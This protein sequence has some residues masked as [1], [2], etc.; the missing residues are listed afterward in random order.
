MRINKYLIAIWLICETISPNAANAH[1]A[2]AQ[3]ISQIIQTN[4]S[5]KEFTC[6]K[7]RICGVL[8]IP[9]FYQNRGWAPAWI[10]SDGSLTGNVRELINALQSSPLEGLSPEIYHLQ[11]VQNLVSDMHL[12]RPGLDPDRFFH[13]AELDILLTDSFLLYASHLRSGRVNPETI[14]TEWVAFHTEIDLSAIL[15]SALINGRI[16]ETLFQLN[17]PHPGYRR[18]KDALHN[19]RRI[20]L[21]GEWEQIHSGPAL[22]TGEK[23]PRVIMLRKRLKISEDFPE[24]IPEEPSFFD[25][26]LEQA[27]K[28]FQRRHGLEADGVAGKNTLNELNKSIEQR[29]RQIELNMERWRW[30][31]H[32]L[33]RRY[34]L[35]NIADFVLEVV[36]EGNPIL[37]MRVVVGRDY[38]RTPVFSETMKYIVLNPFWEVPFSIA[39]K[40]KLPLIQ[41]DTAYLSK[42]NFRVFN[43]WEENAREIDPYSI[44]WSSIGRHNFIY[45][46]RQEPGPEN[47]LGQIKFM[48]PNRFSVY[49]HHT[50]Q[51]ELFNRTVRTFSSGCIRIEKPL[52]LAAYVLGND[53]QWSVEGIRKAIEAG[54]NRTIFLKHPIPV[55]LLYWTAWVDPDGVVNFWEDVYD[56]D[57]PLDQALK[58]KLPDS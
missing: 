58:E 42:N 18:L 3:H 30:I 37:D 19:Y 54:D 45:R 50:P 40:D 1:P 10:A 48:F 43:G 6:G 34:I 16:S 38:R 4:A 27:L 46:L 28:R 2:V 5:E 39:V 56:R 44:D 41:K 26:K 36:E 33:G 32:D 20:A 17:P 31:P 11:K 24:P 49:L 52:D 22:K 57:I 9:Q 53:P 47:A 13:L 15:T 7:E 12:S 14:H 23:D 35:V 21:A 25:A 55:H 8:L 51:R 29:I